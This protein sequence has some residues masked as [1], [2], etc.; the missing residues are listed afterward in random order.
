MTKI[1]PK[2]SPVDV[3]EKVIPMALVLGAP[4]PVSQKKESIRSIHYAFTKRSRRQDFLAVLDEVGGHH[5]AALVIS[6][7]CSLR[8]PA[9]FVRH[10]RYSQQYRD[11]REGQRISVVDKRY[12]S[13][14]FTHDYDDHCRDFTIGLGTWSEVEQEFCHAVACLD[15]LAL[16]DVTSRN[17]IGDSGEELFFAGLPVTI[18]QY[19][20][21]IQ[22]FVAMCKT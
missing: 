11:P 10:C 18:T 13:N 22:G 2:F 21:H 14:A 1:N 17:L 3:S 15:A 8:W 16:Y 6:I 20:E 5:E 4:F 9:A 7:D 19:G 12:L